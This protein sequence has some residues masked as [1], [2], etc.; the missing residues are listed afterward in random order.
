MQNRGPVMR[1]REGI[2]YLT[3]AD[4]PPLNAPMIDIQRLA[5]NIAERARLA[6]G[7]TL[8][9]LVGQLGGRVFTVDEDEWDREV[10]G[11]IIVHGPGD[12]DV[13][14]SRFTSP[15]RDRFTLAHE[16]GHY[17][18]HSLQ[19]K[20]PIIAQR[21]GSGRREWE[22][23]WFA[24]ALLMPADRFRTAYRENRDPRHL[25]WVFN[26]S[27]PAVKVRARALNLD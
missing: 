15:L 24:A 14:I 3:G 2:N 20:Q 11:S 27:I 22:A 1:P 13:A 19:G 17:F 12:F 4:I 18:L 26:V 9:D 23:N 10:S 6:H 21:Y 7:V 25:S 8:F 5:E 16:L